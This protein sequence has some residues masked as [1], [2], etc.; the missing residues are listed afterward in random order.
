MDC[1]RFRESKDQ[2]ELLNVITPTFPIVLQLAQ[3]CL[4][5]PTDEA[6]LAVKLACK[7]FLATVSVRP[8][9]ASPRAIRRDR[10]AP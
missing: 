8:A 6:V 9:H 10:R 1:R 7:C 2:T 5:L 3:A 4:A